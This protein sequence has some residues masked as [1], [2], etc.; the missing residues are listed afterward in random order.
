MAVTIQDTVITIPTYGIGAAD[1]NPQFIEKRVYQGSSGRVYPYPV[2]ET[3]SDEKHDKAYK[4]V[5]I[6]NEY[7]E[8]TVLPELGGRI[9]YAKDKTNNYDFVYRNDVIKPALVGLTGPWISGGI[10]FNWPQHHRPTTYS[11]VD[12]DIKDLPDGGKAV[13]CH[14]TDQMY[15]TQVVTTI[16]LHPGK[17][18][19]E[20]TAQLY[21]GTALPQTFLWWANPAVPVN[22][23]TKTVMP[24]DVTAVMDHGKRDVS[25]YPIATG[26]YYK[27]DYSRGVDI[28]RYKNVPVPTSYMAAHSDYNFVGGYDFGVGAGILHVADHHVSPGKKQWTWG[29]GDFGRAWD[30]NLTD[31]NGPYVELMTGVFTDNQPDF[32][33]LKPYEGKIFTQYFMPYKAV[34]QVKNA[35]INAAVNLEIGPEDTFGS[36]GETEG[37]EAQGLK[38]GQGRV[39]VYATSVYENATVTV[40]TKSGKTLYAYTGAISPN[41]TVR[42]EFETGE[43]PA[44]EI[45]ATVADANGTVLIDYTPSPKKIDK[46]PEPAKAADDPEKIAT[47]EELLLAGLHL[48]QYRHATYMPDPYYLEGLKRD[49]EDARINNAYG[50]LQL[51]RGV[52]KCAEAHFRTAIKRLTKHNTQPYDSEPHYNLGLVLFLQGKYDEAFDAFFKATWDDTQKE[53]AFFYMAAIAARRGDFADALE[54][55]NNALTRNTMNIKARGLKA[56]VLRKLGR[57]DEAATALAENLNIDEFDFVSGYERVLAGGEAA[58][59]E[60]LMRG[61][62]ENYLQAA[63][64]YVLF[65]AYEEA[66]GLL[67]KADQSKPMVKY[68]EGYYL[69]ELGRETEAK[70]AFEAAEAAPSDYCFPN[71][72]EDIAPLEKAIE[73]VDGAKAPY[74]LGC[75]YYDKVQADKAIA[76]WEQSRD[77]DPEFPTVHRNLALAY[78]NKRGDAAAAK[79][80]IEQA[81]ALD[82]SDARVF[83]ETDQL[84]RKIGWT[85]AQ[86]LTEFEKHLDVVAKRDDL[87]IEYLTVLNLTGN[88]AKAY[89]LM[90]QRRFHPWEGGE[91]KITGQYRIALTLL[92]KDAMAA[93]DWAK[94]KE[95]LVKTLAYPKNLGEG[96]LEGQKDNDIHY[97]LGVVERHLGNEEAARA[98]FRQATIGPDEVK[99]AMYY[100][101][102]PAEMILFQGLA[103][104]ALGEEGPAN[105]RFY[106]LLDYGEQH[107]DDQVK[108]DY[109]AVSLPDFLIFENDY[110]K[111]NRVHCEYLM[112]LANI[113][114]GEHEEAERFLTEALAADPS[115]IQ[116]NLF[117]DEVMNRHIL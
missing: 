106:R 95:L 39:T 13:L 97:Y 10:E 107:L 69:A 12:Y 115:H 91:G 67:A 46:L 92:A 68:Y 56:Y 19:I 112:G 104:K 44:T 71:K 117:T 111:M 110:T 100:N 70:A 43:T 77:R 11:P 27:H 116:A 72:L 114:R 40:T 83:L 101:D 33:W 102:Q 17:A 113:G 52:F 38:A 89:E 59:L 63:R 3:I 4:A 30:R 51:R 2:I 29:N 20:I 35:S 53:R 48:E 1:K 5:I 88:Y 93:G 36:A 81:Y 47:N 60:R 96:K 55:V 61:F 25:R 22:E 6:E 45:T 75:L 15:G 7:L 42:A 58:E 14:D 21:N 8:I 49:P 82:E 65:G 85:Y 24:P 90:S 80:E 9:Q 79:V 32:T 31:A 99:G 28:G 94:A 62:F 16:A 74:Y 57:T 73:V 64:D 109:F 34:G 76:L 86:R 18:Y 41:D 87:F 103:H 105:A 37:I 78:Y 84:H 98:E 23:H 50:R 66:L 54:Y 26:T 108:I